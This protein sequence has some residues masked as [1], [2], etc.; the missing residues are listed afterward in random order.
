MAPARAEGCTIVKPRALR[1]VFR[2]AEREVI[3]LDDTGGP[4][5]TRRI[6]WQ[7][8]ELEDPPIQGHEILAMHRQLA[9]KL[10]P[11]VRPDGAIETRSQVDADAFHAEID[12]LDDAAFEALARAMAACGCTLLCYW[13]DERIIHIRG[14]LAEVRKAPR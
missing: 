11:H 13:T 12:A 5:E 4:T 10:P 8:T 1:V 14:H 3:V 6:R 7:F 9:S 2:G